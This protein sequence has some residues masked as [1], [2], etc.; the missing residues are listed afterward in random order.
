MKSVDENAYVLRFTPRRK[1]SIWSKANRERAEKL[2]AAGKMEALGLEAVEAAR[3]NGRW[4]DAYSSKETPD[5]PADLE[6]A[7]SRN[8]KA[9]ANFLEMANSYKT[10]YIFWILGAKKPQTRERRIAE[11]VKRAELNK[12]P[13]E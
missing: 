13:G 4:A 6:Q 11:V 2:M 5:T 12:R 9:Q 1:N 7:L 3:E 10:N 8:T